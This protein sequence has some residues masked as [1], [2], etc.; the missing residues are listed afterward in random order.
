MATVFSDVNL[1]SSAVGDNDLVYDIEAIR[2][3]LFNIF[4]THAG[5]RLFNPLFG[6]NLDSLLFEPMD[7]TTAFYI[8]NE[9]LLGIERWEPRISI[10]KARTAVVPDYDNQVYAITLV[11][12]IP[13]IDAMDTLTFNMAK[14]K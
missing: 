12:S 8:K 5:E 14:S 3:S 10:N 9:I 7:D 11:Y 6:S 13:A 4:T 2:L 1:E